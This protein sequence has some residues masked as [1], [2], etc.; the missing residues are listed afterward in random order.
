MKFIKERKY[1][2]I[3]T[4]IFILILIIGLKAYDLFVPV[5]G[6]PVYGERLKDQNK[7]KIESTVLDKFKEANAS[8]TKLKETTYRVS[9]RVLNIFLVVDDGMSINDAKTLGN[10]VITNLTE[11]I[12][13]Y[14]SVQ[15]FVSKTDEAQNNFPIIG[16][17]DPLSQNVVWTKDRAITQKE[18]G[19]DEQK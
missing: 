12:L 8:N 2:V 4:I 10:S 11:D 17:K 15:I 19:T 14:Y 9:G 7:H 16:L 5:E 3:F 13:G 6:T 18:V 1:T